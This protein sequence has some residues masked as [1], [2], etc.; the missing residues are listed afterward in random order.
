MNEL[1]T[2]SIEI[3]KAETTFIE[4]HEIY[5]KLIPLP[6]SQRDYEDDYLTDYNI[7]AQ[8][9]CELDLDPEPFHG[10]YI[11]SKGGGDKG[12]EETLKVTYE[13]SSSSQ[14]LIGGDS[15]HYFTV[16][17][18]IAVDFVDEMVVH[19]GFGK[20]AVEDITKE[21]INVN[22]SENAYLVSDWCEEKEE[23]SK[24]K[25]KDKENKE[26]SETEENGS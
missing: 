15:K 8:N 14:M 11:E 26:Q 24:K 21:N 7:V 12:E 23:E 5:L 3:I 1:S 22:L 16:A 25:D 4:T 13:A 17:S 10:K 20:N 19:G 2:I 6:G 18:N 9:R